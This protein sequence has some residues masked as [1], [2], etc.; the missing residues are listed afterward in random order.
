[1]LTSTHILRLNGARES[2]GSKTVSPGAPPPRHSGASAA[3]GSDALDGVSL[4]SVASRA[5]EDNDLPAFTLLVGSRDEASAQSCRNRDA[6]LPHSK[7]ALQ[8]LTWMHRNL[9]IKPEYIT[10]RHDSV[11]FVLLCA[12]PVAR[13][14]HVIISLFFG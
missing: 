14:N 2:A 5:A 9:G 10:Q 3:S 7:L 6:G 8:T 11:F 12:L 4:Q 13:C 1:M